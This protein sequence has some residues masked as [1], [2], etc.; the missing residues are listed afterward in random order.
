MVGVWCSSSVGNLPQPPQRMQMVG[1]PGGLTISMPVR[2]SICLANA[3][4]KPTPMQS[5]QFFPLGIKTGLLG[6][7]PLK[8]RPSGAKF[9]DV[10]GEG[11]GLAGA[12]GGSCLRKVRRLVVDCIFASWF[13]RRKRYFLAFGE[14]SDGCEFQ[15]LMVSFCLCSV[16][17]KTSRISRAH[18]AHFP[19]KMPR[20]FA[21]FV[22][23]DNEPFI[24]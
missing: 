14:G 20:L 3:T 21:I 6:A 13:W 9:G 19:W 4:I 17:E 8:R 23:S 16:V 12:C 7:L 18:V 22:G 11:G 15:K 10:G 1:D 5:G 24:A 2:G